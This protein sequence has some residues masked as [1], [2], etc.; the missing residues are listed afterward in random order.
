MPTLIDAAEYTINEIYEIAA[1]DPVEGAATGASFAGIGVSN[2]PHQQLANRTAFLYGRQ[3]T[4]IAN[5]ATLLA[6][7]AGFTGNLAQNGY[8]KVPIGGQK[9]LAQWGV[10]SIPGTVL[11]GDTSFSVTWPIAFPTGIFVALS[12]NLYNATAGENTVISV[13]SG[14]LSKTGGTFMYDMNNGL[15]AAIGGTTHETTDGFY[16][17]AIGY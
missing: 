11:H 1:T 6:F 16:W 8:I 13:D 2:E 14:T 10:Y 7:M 4:N 5:I 17:L 12:T 3:N 15:A 9:F